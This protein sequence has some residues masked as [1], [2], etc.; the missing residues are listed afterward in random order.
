MMRLR[1]EQLGKPWIVERGDLDSGAA[2]AM[3]VGALEQRNELQAPIVHTDK[4][5]VLVDRPRDRVAG[6][7]EIGLDVAQQLERIFPDAVALVDECE[8]RNT[9][10]LTDGEQ[11][12]GSILDALAVVE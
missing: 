3:V 8:N 4:C 2:G 9:A 12:T 5:A 7:V 1:A 11:L 6:D 10:S